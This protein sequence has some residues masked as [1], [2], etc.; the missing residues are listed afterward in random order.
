MWG[1]IYNRTYLLAKVMSNVSI[2][3]NFKTTDI[4]E[5]KPKF[6]TKCPLAESEIL[7]QLMP[8]SRARR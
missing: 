3:L 8:V 1:A 5:Q 7:K 4:R 6:Q 2:T